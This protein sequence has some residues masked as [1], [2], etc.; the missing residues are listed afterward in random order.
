MDYSKILSIA[1]YSLDKKDK[2]KM[3]T[4]RIKDLTVKHMENCEAYRKM[5]ESIDFVPEKANGFEDYPFIPVRLFK[6]MELKSVPQEKIFKTLTSSGTSGQAVSKIYLDRTTASNQQKTMVKIVSDFTGAGRMPMLIIDCPSVVKNRMMFSARGAGILGFSMFGS[7]KAYALNDDMQLDIESI[8]AFLKKHEGKKIFMFGFTFMVWQH[9]YQELV[10]LTDEGI[11]FD[12]SKGILIHGGGWKKLV[13][14]A[15][16][17]EEFHQ[18]LKDVCGLNSIHDYYGMVEQTGCIYMQCECGHLHASI[19][20]DV[21]IRNPK[22]FSICEE[23]ETG[24][25]QV[26]SAIPESY[27]GHSLLT[28]DEGFIL[29]EDDCPCG[30]KGKYFKILGRLRNAEV[31]GCSD[32]YAAKFK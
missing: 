17:P 11:K 26:V 20:S 28:E 25:I 13:S 31:R 27:P 4:E 15:V 18:R 5:M 9:F 29:G 1:P 8:Q 16:T 22:D 7:D 32:T 19:F 10:R 12:L 30:R 6:E 21:I 3:L 24:I 23:G 14:E 2:M